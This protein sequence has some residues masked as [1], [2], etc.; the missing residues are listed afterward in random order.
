ML[1]ILCIS[2]VISLIL[3]IA[4][5][6]LKEGWLEGSSILIA[7]VIIVTVTAGNNYIKEQQF[8]KLNAVA[9]Q[10]DVEVIRGSAMEPM[11]V[12][13]LLVGDIVSVTT[14]EIISVDGI[15]ISGH[16]VAAD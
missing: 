1:R 8:Q 13:K 11:S 7:V 4:T 2:A 3:G 6:G 14:G 5:E 16:D 12:Y 15:L 9:Q 10:K